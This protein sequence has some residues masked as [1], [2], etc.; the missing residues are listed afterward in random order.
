MNN[1]QVIEVKGQRVLTTRQIAEAYGTDVKI[2]NNNYTRN[3]VRYVMGKHFIPVEGDELKALK[4]THHQIE[5]ELKRA[6]KAFFWTEKGALLHAKSLNTDKAWEVYDYLVDFYFHAKKEDGAKQ[7]SRKNTVVPIRT[8][9]EKIHEGIEEKSARRLSFEDNVK[10]DVFT[11]LI[12]LAE[13]LGGEVHFVT[14]K[15]KSEGMMAADSNLENLRIGIKSGMDF[16][17]Y[18]YNIAHELASY[19]LHY[20]K[21]D[22][23][24]SDRHKKYEEQADRGAKMLLKALA[25][26]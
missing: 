14:F 10:M 17:K 5:G 24:T 3:K 15:S 1:L 2:I 12:H 7:A 25:V 4:S 16:E 11:K 23:I 6:H 21:G 18:M 19:F 8:R 13:D 9:V 20:D 26:K 22:T